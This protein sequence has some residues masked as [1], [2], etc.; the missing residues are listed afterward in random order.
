MKWRHK[1]LSNLPLVSTKLKHC[2]IFNC[3]IK[4]IF[5]ISIFVKYAMIFIQTYF[6]LCV[7][8][9]L[10][11]CNRYFWALTE[12]FFG[13]TE[14]R[15]W[16]IL[17][18]YRIQKEEKSIHKRVSLKKKKSILLRGAEIWR[19]PR[20]FYLA[21]FSHDRIPWCHVRAVHRKIVTHTDARLGVNTIIV[22]TKKYLLLNFFCKSI[23]EIRMLKG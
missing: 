10:S 23:L 9:K 20:P 2:I 5:R 3:E 17:F 11:F 14:I 7:S 13:K 19:Y 22:R 12:G 6:N 15:F 21:S 8:H 1:F 18:L 4:W 16:V